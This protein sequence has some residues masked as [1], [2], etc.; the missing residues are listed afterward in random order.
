MALNVP[1]GIF[2]LLRMIHFCGMC[3]TRAWDWRSLAG[4]FSFDVGRG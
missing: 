2:W 4:L 1:S 3:F